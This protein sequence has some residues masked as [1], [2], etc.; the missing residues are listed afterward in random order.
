MDLCGGVCS[1][2]GLLAGC[3][4]NLGD[5]WSHYPLT[6]PSASLV[7]ISGPFMQQQALQWLS[8]KLLPHQAFGSRCLDPPRCVFLTVFREKTFLAGKALL[9]AAGFSQ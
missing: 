6:I 2:T 4:A 7:A 9:L 5:L 3:Q 8:A 1:G